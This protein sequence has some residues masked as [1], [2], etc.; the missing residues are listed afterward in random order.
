VQDV[1]QLF[2]RY[3]LSVHEEGLDGAPGLDNVLEMV[4]CVHG[5]KRALI[6]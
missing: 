2:F 4:E 5:L 6:T 1:G 3:H